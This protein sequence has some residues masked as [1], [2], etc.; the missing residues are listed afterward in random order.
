MIINGSDPIDGDSINSLEKKIDNLKD[1]I[2]KLL[3]R[4]SVGDND[5][6][7]ASNSGRPLQVL[8]GS[9]PVNVR[10]GKENTISIEVDFF[11]PFGGNKPPTVVAMPVSPTPYGVSVKRVRRDGFV[12]V[13]H[14]FADSPQDDRFHISSVNYIAVGAP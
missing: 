8:A 1:K 11:Q 9:V 10:V 5:K 14:Q 3:W 7:I 13:I 4:N 6:T 12:L 2:I